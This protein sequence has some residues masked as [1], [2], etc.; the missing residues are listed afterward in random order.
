MRYPAMFIAALVIPAS[1]V[2]HTGPHDGMGPVEAIAHLLG[3]HY[4]PELAGE[5]VLPRC[6]SWQA[7]ASG[8]EATHLSAA[9]WGTGRANDDFQTIL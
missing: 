7:L 9:S 5:C 2:A 4:A 1:A 6:C 3:Q 8:K